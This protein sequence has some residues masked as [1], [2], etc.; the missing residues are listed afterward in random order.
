MHETFRIEVSP[1]LIPH[2]VISRSGLPVLNTRISGGEQ[3]NGFSGI[4]VGIL[5]PFPH[6]L[7]DSLAYGDCKKFF[8]DV[9]EDRK[10]NDE[11][12]FVMGKLGQDEQK[13]VPFH[14]FN[15]KKL[16]I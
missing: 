7:A 4:T 2:R 5:S 11:L 6:E 15:S 9:S 13:H 14:V 3:Y 1:D 16:L 12:V 10:S 8:R